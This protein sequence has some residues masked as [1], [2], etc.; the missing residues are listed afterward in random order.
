[1]EELHNVQSYKQIKMHSQKAN[2]SD[3]K[4]VYIANFL[5]LRKPVTNILVVCHKK[6]IPAFSRNR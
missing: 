2:M 6:E 4:F 1:M 5:K 3:N